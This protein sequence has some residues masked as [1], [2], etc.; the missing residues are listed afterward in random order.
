[1]SEQDPYLV[2]LLGEAEDVIKKVHGYSG[3][4]GVKGSSVLAPPVSPASPS[5]GMPSSVPLPTVQVL[6]NANPRSVGSKSF[7]FILLLLLL[8]AL[9]LLVYPAR[10]QSL[11]RPPFGSACASYSS[12]SSSLP[13]LKALGVT[14]EEYDNDGGLCPRRRREDRL[15]QGHRGKYSGGQPT[16]MRRLASVAPK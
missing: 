8:I 6:G 7:W 14:F 16:P 12:V 4:P 11:P 1:M 10:A 3:E 15:V 13:E 9:F 2:T 5:Q